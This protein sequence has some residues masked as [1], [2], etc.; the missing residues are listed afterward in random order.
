MFKGNKFPSKCRLNDQLSKVCSPPLTVRCT[1]VQRC[2]Q[3]KLESSVCK[4]WSPLR[5]H[6]Q[7]LGSKPHSSSRFCMRVLGLYGSLFVFHARP[8][9]ANILNV[10]QANPILEYFYSGNLPGTVTNSALGS[11]KSYSFPCPKCQPLQAEACFTTPS[12]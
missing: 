11:G 8:L 5:S 3:P 9:Q 7:R 1:S 4:K 12:H 6:M 10:E 2:T